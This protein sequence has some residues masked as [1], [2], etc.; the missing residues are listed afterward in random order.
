M[1]EGQNRD[2]V[3]EDDVWWL[4]LPKTT[5]ISVLQSEHGAIIAAASK[6]RDGAFAVY[7][8]RGTDDVFNHVEDLPDLEA[9]SDYI[10]VALPKAVKELERRNQR[11]PFE[12]GFNSDEDGGRWMHSDDPISADC[13]VTVVR[14]RPDGTEE[15]D[16][17]RG[18]GNTLPF[19]GLMWHVPLSTW[20]VERDYC[21]IEIQDPQGQVTTYGSCGHSES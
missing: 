8:R 5:Y 3:S 20:L 11:H 19:P 14:H 2:R 12:F 7:L 17:A 10:A 4:A 9:C 18:G 6:R 21:H 1:T 15:R 13:Y 16:T